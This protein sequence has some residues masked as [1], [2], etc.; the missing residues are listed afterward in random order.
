MPHF[1]TGR[2]TNTQST[3][4]NRIDDSTDLAILAR[5]QASWDGR[6]FVSFRRAGLDRLM[7]KIS[8]LAGNEREKGKKG[9]LALASERRDA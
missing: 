5:A 6:R 1:Q 2:E 3:K 8:V 4:E 9:L 7:I